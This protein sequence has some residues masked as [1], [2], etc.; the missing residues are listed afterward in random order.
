MVSKRSDGLR[1]PCNDLK[2]TD[3]EERRF[4]TREGIL[5]CRKDPE[6]NKFH[7]L[8]VLD[9]DQYPIAINHDFLKELKQNK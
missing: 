2:N 8:A 7:T 4:E 9:E 3:K 5:V 1:D 6:E